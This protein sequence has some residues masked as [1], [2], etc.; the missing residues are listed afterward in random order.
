MNLKMLGKV[1]TYILF[2]IGLAFVQ[3]VILL[4]VLYVLE[5]CN[6]Y[7]IQVINFDSALIYPLEL[8]GFFFALIFLTDLI[9]EIIRKI[10]HL[11]YKPMK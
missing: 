4:S 11:Y 3:T 9:T 6:I 5:R 1:V 10:A 7:S 8:G 2:L